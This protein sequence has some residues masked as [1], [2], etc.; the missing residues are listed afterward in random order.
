[1]YLKSLLMLEANDQTL[2]GSRYIGRHHPFGKITIYLWGWM[3]GRYSSHSTFI[4]RKLTYTV[5]IC[6]HASSAL[7]VSTPVSSCS[8]SFVDFGSSCSNKSNWTVLSY[9]FKDIHKNSTETTCKHINKNPF[10]WVCQRRTALTT[11]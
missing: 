8:L 2:V 1:M 11:L 6:K 3:Q 4:C 10:Q 9:Y 7:F 5:W